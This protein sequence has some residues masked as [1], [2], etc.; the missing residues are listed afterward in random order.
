M[1]NLETTA[2][3]KEYV[4]AGFGEKVDGTSPFDAKVLTQLNRAWRLVVAGGA[5]LSERFGKPVLFPWAVSQFPV[6]VNMVAPETAGTVTCTLG[7]TA[8]TL[9]NAPSVATTG[10]YLKVDGE[11]EVYRVAAQAGVNLTLDAAYVGSTVTTTYK[12][13]KNRYDF[14]GD[15]LVPV[16]PIRVYGSQRDQ[17]G[18]KKIDLI[19]RNAM[20][21]KWPLGEIL[22]DFPTKAAVVWQS[23]GTLTVRLNTYAQYAERMEMDYVKIP[24]DLAVGVDP[25]I[26]PARHRVVLA[27]WALFFMFREVDDDRMADQM[28]IAEVAFAALVEESRGLKGAAGDQ[29][30]RV[31]P[32]WEENVGDQGY[33]RTSDGFII[34]Y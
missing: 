19:G 26:M 3:L 15:I 1:A 21:K 14:G 10:W 24:T 28:G 4:L 20:D 7:S 22:Q 8:A 2:D 17:D 16:S 32:R 6:V 9:T 33:L 30:G 12:M 27:E 13:F 34:G 23:G 18:A 11:Y 5:G 25:T 31:V 29:A